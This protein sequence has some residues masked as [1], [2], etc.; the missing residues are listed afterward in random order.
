MN[1]GSLGSLFIDL[2]A[3]T[4][5]FETDLGRA[6]RL[7][8]QRSKEMQE[9]F[10]KAGEKILAA[11]ESYKIGERL[12]E[13]VKGA[14]EQFDQVG[15]AAQKI[16]IATEQLSELAYA[17][18]LS[19]VDFQALTEGLKKFNEAQVEAR[20][21]GK[22]QVAA[23]QAIGISARDLKTLSPDQLLVKVANA[24]AGAR[25][26]ADKT[27][28][29]IALFG[30]A[31]A[32]LIPWL[33]QGGKAMADAAEEAKKLHAAL[34]DEASKAAD[35]FNTNLTKLKM[36]VQGVANLAA[37]RLLPTLLEFSNQAVDA[38]EQADNLDRASRVLEAGLKLLGE[39]GL[40]VSGTFLQLGTITGGLAAAWDRIGQG[41]KLSDLKAG[42][43][44]LKDAF[45]DV[46]AIG[47]QYEQRMKR[48]WD[49]VA[50]AKK[51]GESI[52][53]KDQL[54]DWDG[55]PLPEKHVLSFNPQA[56]EA[57]KRS[58]EAIQAAMRTYAA[59]EN[60]AQG[61]KD[62]AAAVAL[63]AEVET[64]KYAELD[65]LTKRRLLVISD[66]IEQEEKAA[67][68]RKANDDADKQIAALEAE[69]AGNKDL[70]KSEALRFEIEKGSLKGL[71][72]LQKQQLRNKAD[73]LAA[74][75]K[76]AKQQQQR[77]ETARRAQQQFGK[78][79]NVSGRDFS[80]DLFDSHSFSQ[81]GNAT[82]SA[83]G[84]EDDR[85]QKE[86]DAYKDSRKEIEAAGEDFDAIML[87][88][89]RKHE[90]EVARIKK[91]GGDAQRSILQNQFDFGAAQ[92]DALASL[93]DKNTKGGFERWKE[94]EIASATLHMI[95]GAIGAFAQGASAFPP[96]YGEVAGGVAAAL[97]LATGAAQIA[98]I[99]S[100]QFGGG[101][102]Y[103]GGVNAGGMYEVA[104]P[105]N[106]ELL[107]Y[108]SKTMLLMGNQSG[109]VT[110]ARA[111]P[112]MTGG[113]AWQIVAENHGEPLDM[114]IKRV[115][116]NVV[117][118]EMMPAYTGRVAKSIA[119][120][121]KAEKN[122][123]RI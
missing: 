114:R 63:R 39:A 13:S 36:A 94:F 64:G 91:Q 34:S 104:E 84:K 60:E 9:S 52:K 35:E 19:D 48:L 53:D 15:K 92:F 67:A 120:R 100:T 73:L 7:A 87:A 74:D 40:I 96:P 105:G 103:G 109:T 18:K 90:D 20:N 69:I 86:V 89:A 31:G 80:T 17:A 117:T 77:E 43:D 49:G 70:A 75:E 112:E 30:K 72:D 58:Q 47:E 54:T 83:I 1:L 62:I 106:P 6:A 102:R 113:S 33:N 85:Y 29:A 108:G 65:E 28:I 121:Q 50:A 46:N 56:G 21:G 66:L 122:L 25:D 119:D 44:V 38:A 76:Q 41:N 101:R 12:V 82:R 32:D 99:R 45:A 78:L 55:K 61:H 42:A 107:R 4:A 115:V 59:L 71:D 10:L 51:L 57:L 118:V 3:N 93:Q 5:K 37:E 110:P 26:N 22:D 88:A 68:F 11:Y 24:F 95:S 97:V 81:A 98:Q 14:I 116:G 2:A 16:G 111:A 79:S 8:E 123:R 23:F 27:R